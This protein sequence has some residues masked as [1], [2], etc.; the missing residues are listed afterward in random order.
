MHAC[1]DVTGFGL[2]GHAMEMAT[3]TEAGETFRHG[4][5][6]SLG[7]SAVL[8]I[9]ESHLQLPP[10]IAEEARD[11]LQAY[12]LPVSFSASKYG[13]RRQE[14]IDLCMKLM[15]K[16]KKRKDNRLRFI[17]IDTLGHAGVHIGVPES[18]IRAA[19]NMV[20]EE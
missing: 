2:A 11:L 8:A 6:V 5:G 15:L 12:K 1:T 7:I 10:D 9:G 18:E 13:Y 16:D 14:L 20:I 17:L 19:F 4:E 3:H